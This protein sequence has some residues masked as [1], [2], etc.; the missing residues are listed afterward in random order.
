[1]KASTSPFPRAQ[2]PAALPS[3]LPILVT[4]ASYEAVRLLSRAAEQPLRPAGARSDPAGE[5]VAAV[6]VGA[7]LASLA[8]RLGG[9]ARSRWVALTLLLFASVAAVMLEGSA[10]APS[11]SPVSA[12]PLGLVEQL[13]VSLLTAGVAAALSP[14]SSGRS[15]IGR[16]SLDRF[17]PRVGATALVYVLAYLV[18]G[19]IA[20]SLVTGPYYAAHASGL[21]RPDP[22]IVLAVALAEGVLMTLGALPLTGALRGPRWSRALACGLALWLL[23]GV[24][25]L[26][27]QSTLPDVVRLASAV[28][29]LFQKVPLGIALVWFLVPA[30]PRELGWADAPRSAEAAR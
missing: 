25:P 24:I 26:L 1:M 30:E 18:S 29:I 5:L 21:E 20:Y 9:S 2:A 11:L 23:G 28:E 16:P 6:I 13:G 7:S 17:V 15:T 4:A 3:W 12:I 14:G 27:Q 10:F 8:P 22:S 19:A